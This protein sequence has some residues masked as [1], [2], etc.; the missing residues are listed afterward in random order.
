ML[1]SIHYADDTKKANP[2]QN[3]PELR[4]VKQMAA[5]FRTQIVELIVSATTQYV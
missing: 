3:I 1:Y 2:F 5:Q 4:N